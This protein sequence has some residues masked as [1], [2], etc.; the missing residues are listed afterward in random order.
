MITE[1]EYEKVADGVR[2]LTYIGDFNQNTVTIPDSIDAMPVVTIGAQCFPKFSNI[3][4]IVLPN[5]LKKIEFSA[6][7]S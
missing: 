7:G 1:F 3:K 2:L 4:N 5:T 6:F